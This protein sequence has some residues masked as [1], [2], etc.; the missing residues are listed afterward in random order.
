MVNGDLWFSMVTQQGSS[1]V[2][3]K[4]WCVERRERERDRE[5]ERGLEKETGK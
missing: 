3:G 1:G 4:R 5:T 2:G